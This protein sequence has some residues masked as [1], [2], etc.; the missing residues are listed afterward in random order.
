MGTK[1]QEYFCTWISPPALE[2]VFSRCVIV[3]PDHGVI[4]REPCHAIWRSKDSPSVSM[5]DVDGRSES[6]LHREKPEPTP[7]DGLC[8]HLSKLLT[9]LYLPCHTQRNVIGARV[10]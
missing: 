5:K 10:F 7:H 2:V 9:R 3:Q 4:G 8:F 6:S 1:R